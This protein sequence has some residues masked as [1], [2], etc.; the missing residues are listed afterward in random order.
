MANRTAAM[1]RKAGENPVVNKLCVFEV[2]IEL[3]EWH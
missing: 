3:Y 1:L 2:R